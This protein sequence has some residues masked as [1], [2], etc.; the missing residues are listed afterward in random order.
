MNNCCN[1][2]TALDMGCGTI[3]NRINSLDIVKTDLKWDIKNFLESV[4]NDAELSIT[5][6]PIVNDVFGFIEYSHEVEIKTSKF[7]PIYFKALVRY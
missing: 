3:E 1:L 4:K 5:L 7:N 6:T 2:P